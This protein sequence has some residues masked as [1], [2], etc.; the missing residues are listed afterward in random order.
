[1]AITLGTSGGNET[2]QAVTVGT[3][4]GNRPVIAGYVGTSGGNKQIFAALAAV[5]DPTLL[6]VTFGQQSTTS[7]S[8]TVVVTGGIGPFTYSWARVSGDE[9]IVPTSS[10]TATTAFRAFLQ[11]DDTYSASFVCTVTDTATGAVASAPALGVSF[12]WAGE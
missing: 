7:D 2:L 4:S 5:N 6:P 3:S 8:V 10:T 12:F 1:M 11:Q 9:E